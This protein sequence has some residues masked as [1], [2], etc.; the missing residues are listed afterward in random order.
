MTEGKKK[1]IG[2]EKG[3]ATEKQ[4]KTIAKQSEKVNNKTNSA[5]YLKQKNNNKL[6]T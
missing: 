1:T 6:T 5:Q 4:T 2:Y 3:I